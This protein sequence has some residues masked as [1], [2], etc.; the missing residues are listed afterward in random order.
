M[1]HHP[2][3]HPWLKPLKFLALIMAFGGCGPDADEKVDDSKKSS[4]DD[5]G[6]PTF[7]IMILGDS[8]TEGY[9]VPEEEA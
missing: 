7:R 6:T 1:T 3:K 9:G 2:T 8:L 4:T 5:S